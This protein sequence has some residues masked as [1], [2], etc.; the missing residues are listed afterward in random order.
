MFNKVIQVGRL[1]RDV[2]LK[3]INNFNVAKFTLANNRKWKDKNTNQER[4][5]VLFVE[6]VVFGAI[7]INLA[8]YIRKGSQ[9]LVDGRLKLETWTDKQGQN[10]NKII[11]VADTVQFL[12]SKG[13]N[14]GT[15]RE[16]APYQQQQHQNNNNQ[17]HN[18]NNTNKDVGFVND[19]VP[20]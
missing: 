14:Q 16:P 1:V 18:F 13:T 15:N 19:D 9:V 3:Q 11:I 8:K 10:R 12:D 6:V 4:E 7:A 17:N 5:E 20:F 2:E